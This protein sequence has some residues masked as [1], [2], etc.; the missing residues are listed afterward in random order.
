MNKRTSIAVGAVI[1]AAL[2]G[3]LVVPTY[4]LTSNNATE[5]CYIIYEH[6]STVTNTM[7]DISDK[8]ETA[9]KDA[10][11]RVTNQLK[12]AQT[13]G[14]GTTQLE[15]DYSTVNTD[16][17]KFHA[18]RLVLEADLTNA[19]SAAPTECGSGGGQFAA[20][21]KTAREQLPILRA[22][23]VQIRVAIR[24]KLIPDIRAYADWLKNKASTTTN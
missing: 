23:D 3:S 11:A 2:A 5:R 13:A 12:A 18:D 21:L 20:A 15:A 7:H 14:Y 4:A 24:Q 10:I 22:D 16:L 17:Q 1:A 19:Q 6:I 9:Y 8:R